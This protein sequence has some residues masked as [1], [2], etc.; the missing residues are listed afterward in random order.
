MI[1]AF[2]RISDIFFD[3]FMDQDICKVVLG[4]IDLKV[5]ASSEGIAEGFIIFI[6]VEVYLGQED[7]N[8]FFIAK[9]WVI[10]EFFSE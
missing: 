2:L 10:K 1:D 3:G 5:F 7:C 8:K 6:K 4:A 9:S